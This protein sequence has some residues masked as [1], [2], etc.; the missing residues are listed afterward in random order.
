MKEELKPI[1][2]EFQKESVLQKEESSLH[3]LLF[4]ERNHLKEVILKIAKFIN[5]VLI[6]MPNHKRQF[7]IINSYTQL[8]SLEP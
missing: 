5:R 8:S 1:L 7:Q 4:Q 3:N 6:R 2:Q